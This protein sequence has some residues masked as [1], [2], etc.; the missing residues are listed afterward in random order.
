MSG[1]GPVVYVLIPSEVR[2]GRKSRMQLQESRGEIVHRL[3]EICSK[4]KSGGK[5]G[6]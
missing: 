2:G 6:R 1:D 4:V 5:V 3:V